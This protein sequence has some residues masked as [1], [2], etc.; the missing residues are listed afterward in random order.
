[1]QFSDLMTLEPHG[2]DTF[3]GVGP[4]YPWGGL[5]GGQIVAQS[6]RAA[7]HSVNPEHRV[8]SLHAYFIRRGQH[9]AP[10]RF[11]VDRIRDGRSFT[12]RRVVARQSAGA[13]L[14]MSCSFSLPEGESDL[15][16]HPMPEVPAADDIQQEAGWLELMQRR[17]VIRD[18]IG[19][20]AAWFRTCQ[21]FGDDPIDH[22]CALAYFSDDF[23]CDAVRLRHPS[24]RDEGGGEFWMT[25]LDHAIW[26]HHPP[27]ADRWMLHDVR[28]QS[29]VGSHGLATA[30]VFSE[31][32]Q[33]VATVTQEALMRPRR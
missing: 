33:H 14:N 27:R 2:P 28:C 22:A 11:E 5:Y 29:L 25:S 16:T 31:E 8:H 21:A 26:F 17:D 24:S 23:P 10:V 18:T 4:R 20:R 7:A 12:T 9:D 6:L 1:M 32:G 19:R 15:Q 30:H 3:V 13:I